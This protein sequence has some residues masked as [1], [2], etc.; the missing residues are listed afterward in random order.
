MTDTNSRRITT[1]E[2]TITTATIEIKT[3]TFPFFIRTSHPCG[4][5]AHRG[6]NPTLMTPAA[7]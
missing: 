4:Y 7:K 3:L 6:P 1:H 2:A 5:A